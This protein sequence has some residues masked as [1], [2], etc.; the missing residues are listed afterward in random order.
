MQHLATAVWPEDIQHGRD[1]PPGLWASR[2]LEVLVA[3]RERDHLFAQDE[4]PS[5]PLEDVAV[6]L[7]ARDLGNKGSQVGVRINL[8]EPHELRYWTKEL[9]VDEAQLRAAVAAAGTWVDTGD[10]RLSRTL[11]LMAPCVALLPKDAIAKASC[12]CHELATP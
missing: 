8:N 3:T 2:R 5:A 1:A 10:R 7:L 9:G 4:H 6:D 12:E 11:N